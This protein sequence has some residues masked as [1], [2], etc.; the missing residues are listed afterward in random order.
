MELLA[1]RDVVSINP[2]LSVSQVTHSIAF[3]LRHSPTRNRL[4]HFGIDNR[5]FC[6]VD[7]TSFLGDYIS[8]LLVFPCCETLRW[9]FRVMGE[10]V[11]W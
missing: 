10:L 11:I 1:I 9:V 5:V 4:C 8:F 2:V 7:Y 6:D 3:K